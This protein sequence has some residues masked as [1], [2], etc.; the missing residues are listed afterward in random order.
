MSFKSCDLSSPVE[1]QPRYLSPAHALCAY[2]HSY[3]HRLKIS[4]LTPLLIFHQDMVRFWVFFKLFCTTKDMLT[5]W[6]VSF[7]SRQHQA[8][9]FIERKSFSFTAKFILYWGPIYV[10]GAQGFFENIMQ[11]RSQVDSNMLRN[12]LKAEIELKAGDLTQPWHISFLL[13]GS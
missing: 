3:S 13:G 6:F 4:K 9:H 1:L 7:R 8:V 10:A 2:I 5:S 12:Q 11:S